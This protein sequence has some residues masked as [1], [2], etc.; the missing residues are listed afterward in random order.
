MVV[1][2]EVVV[3]VME[4]RERENLTMLSPLSRRLMSEICPTNEG[5]DRLEFPLPPPPPLPHFPTLD[6]KAQQSC[7]FVGFCDGGVR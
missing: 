1:V 6:V 5:R 3:A 4:S 7:S 2:V